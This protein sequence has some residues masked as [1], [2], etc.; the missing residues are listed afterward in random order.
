M[1]EW[2]QKAQETTETTKSTKGSKAFYSHGCT[3]CAGLFNTNRLAP[4]AGAERVVSRESACHA[5]AC[6]LGYPVQPV[7][8][9]F[10]LCLLQGE[11]C[12]PAALPI[13]SG[14]IW[15]PPPARC[16]RW[17]LA[18]GSWG[19][20]APAI[21]PSPPGPAGPSRT[22]DTG[23]PRPLRPPASLLSECPVPSDRV[24]GISPFQRRPHSGAAGRRRQSPEKRHPLV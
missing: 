21:P 10:F 14:S 23:C 17:M 1:T 4:I 22:P 9:C 6:H 11:K 18:A 15:A 8:P 16:A 3:G 12:R 20:A 13:F 5:I 2:P 7:Y 24:G 19:R